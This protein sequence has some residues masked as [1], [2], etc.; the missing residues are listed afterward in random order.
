MPDKK[1]LEC[2]LDSHFPILV[3]E[4]H[5]EERC[6]EMLK[7]VVRG[8]KRS[9]FTWSAAQGL[10]NRLVG[11]ISELSLV[12]DQ[13]SDSSQDE[14]IPSPREMLARIDRK[15]RNSVVVLLDF[16]PYL[17]DPQTLRQLKEIAHK[18]DEHGNSLVLV[19]HQLSIP[20][21]I[22]R[23][24]TH[25]QLRLPDVDRMRELVVREARSWQLK[26]KEKVGADRKAMDMLVRNLVGLT[27]SDAC[28]LIRNAI[29][30]DGAI[31][32]SDIESVMDA[33]YRMG[34]Q[35]G[36]L[37][38]EYDTARFSDIGG[39]GKLK[40]WLER[41]REYFLSQADNTSP[42]VPKGVLLLGVQGCGKSLAAKTIAGAW[43]I[44]LL[45]MDFGAL[46]NKWI[47]ETEKNIRE[48]LHAAECLAPCVLWVD[49]IEK[50]ISTGG[51]D[52]GTSSRVLGTLLT[53]MAERKSAV[54][55]V[56][57]SNDVSSLPPE[58]M[59]KG[60]IDEIFFVDLPDAQTRKAILSI[61]LKK[62]DQD[63]DNFDLEQL[64]DATEGFSGAELEQAV[65]AARFACRADEVLNTAHLLTEVRQT[66]P[67][68]VVRSE[69]IQRLRQWASERTI[70][71]N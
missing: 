71:A 5:E 37:S 10:K 17:Q 30:D 53:W 39:F 12:G 65:V 45:R 15:L 47:G 22:E 41:R 35:D 52:G 63:P 60:R 18:L 48:A 56:A 66:R 32:H 38:Y 1:N 23:L 6:I 16:H 68:S 25:Y 43:G 55:M 40:T 24:C 26:K 61:H 28:R 58:L 27:E 19:S 69:D 14:D 7:S 13:E 70:P 2:L 11:D 62:R 31:T 4:T 46:F 20:P 8:K 54:F 42:D 21:E 51:Q 33:K 49:E 3:I 29:Y 57:T 67:L 59:R 9:L 64:A 36:I 50:G 34:G 44:P